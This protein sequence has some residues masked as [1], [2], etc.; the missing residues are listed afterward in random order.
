LVGREAHSTPLV[1]FMSDDNGDGKIDTRDVPDIVVPVESVN[2]QI[3]GEIKVISGKDGHEI[4]TAGGPDKVSPW[5]EL[6][7][8]DINGDGFPEIIG[9][10]SDGSHLLAFD[11]SGQ[12]LWT[13]DPNPMP[14]F[15]LGQ[16]V[17]TGAISIAN[18]DG[19][20]PKIIIGASVFDADG[21]L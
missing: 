14:F 4:F 16:I 15:N 8:G 3:T 11:H 5:S 7:V 10:A 20:G 19:T 21:H 1:A 2:S 9:V 13:S 6:A 18:L 17:Y 12:L